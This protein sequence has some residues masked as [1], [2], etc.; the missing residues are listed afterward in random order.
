[1]QKQ[2]NKKN[3]NMGRSK[4]ILQSSNLETGNN[5]QLTQSKLL[6]YVKHWKH[7]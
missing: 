1:M 2:V 7:Q 5:L 4:G 3:K 6:V